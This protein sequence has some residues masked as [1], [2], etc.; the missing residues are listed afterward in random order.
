[1]IKAGRGDRILDELFKILK[2]DAVKVLYSIGQQWP[3]DWKRSAFIPIPKKDSVKD[4]SNY[5]TIVL[6][7][8]TSQ[9]IIKILLKLGFS[10]TGIKNL[11]MYKLGFEEAEEPEIKL[12][13]FTGS[14]RQQG[15][16]R[17]TSASAS[18]TMVKLCLCGIQQTV[19]NS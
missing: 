1:M 16:S 17:K 14:W 4:Y 7:A 19:E 13:T 6:I 2:C 11:Q 18:V 15:N 12:P 8:H 5:H 10:S 3:Q 9:V